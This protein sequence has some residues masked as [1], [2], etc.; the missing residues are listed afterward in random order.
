MTV[1]K[2]LLL[3]LPL[4]VVAAAPP[5]IDESA[6]RA[7]I[8]YLASD[9]LAGRASGTE[10]NEKAAREMAAAFRKAGLESIG[11]SLEND[12]S[13]ALDGSGY[14]QP[15]PFTAGL[16]RGSAN[17]LEAEIAGRKVSYAVDTEFEPSGISGSG[18]AEGQAFFAGYG[19][20]SK[21]PAR[22]DFEGANV[23]GKVLLLLAGWPGN[24]PRSPL[25]EFAGVH[26]KAM[27]ARDRGAVA[28]LL[29]LPADS[30]PPAVSSDE[31]LADEGIPIF[32]VRRSVAEEW[33]RAAGKSLDGVETLLAHAPGAFP[34]P[35]QVRLSAS[36]EKVRRP[37]ANVLGL[38]PG[39]D[40]RLREEV[41]VIGAH[42]D[43]LGMGGASSLSESR[44]PAVHHGADD[45]ASGA[46]GVAALAQLFAS[47]PRP[48]RSLL[49]IG[50]TGEELGL[51][52]SSWYV[53]H[54]AIPLAR[55]VAM[56]N[57]DMIG[58]LRD[59][60][61]TVIGTG[62]SPAWGALLDSANAG[63][64]FQLARTEGGFGASDQQ[65]FYAAKVPVLFFFTGVHPDYHR[66]SDTADKINY[67]GEASVLELVAAC[68]RRVADADER[69]AYRESA[70]GPSPGVTAFRVYLGTIP[71]YSAEVVGVQLTG[72]REGSPAEKAGLRGGDVIVKF[73]GQSIRSVE[74]YAVALGT[75]H[76]GDVVSIELHRAGQTLTV[77]A[78]LEA[79]RP[80]P[81]SP[82]K[83]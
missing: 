35:V 73:G 9:A 21:E 5:G 68:A 61:L 67:D 42:F 79:P 78:T 2:A 59:G 16:A 65:S 40:P 6:L 4:V 7:R 23:R 53:K 31:G 51:L 69:P 34:L 64:K 50:F 26:R 54:P 66:P 18:S 83:P 38:L 44:E 29:V 1:R 45:N 76:P 12:P 36:V 57:M 72:V 10:G 74:D 22:D 11:T 71:D 49:F 32:L 8:A 15:F 14:F 24:D 47:G 80:R 41:V 17:T 43:H 46:A 37:T 19:I 28:V 81:G 60:K 39:S 55:T 20:Q 33:L 27:L 70:A 48:R 52:G 58:R 77:S 75:H 30:R 25:A 56:F 62:T 3:L 82:E 13:A 63:S